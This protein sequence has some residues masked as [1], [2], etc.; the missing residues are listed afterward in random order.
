MESFQSLLKL[1]QTGIVG[2]GT[3]Y[4]IF[5]FMKT[6]EGI[7]G[8]TSQ[9]VSEGVGQLIAGVLIVVAA[10]LISNIKIG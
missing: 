3:M 7:K 1:L 2:Y 4:L 8:K 9:D 6:A 5:G 10:A